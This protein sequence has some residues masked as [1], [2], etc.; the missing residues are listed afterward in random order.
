MQLLQ[1][2][3]KDRAIGFPEDIIADMNYVI[4]CYP[5]DEAIKRSVVELAGSDPV[6]D[7]WLS[8]GATIRDDVC[9]IEQFFVSQPTERTL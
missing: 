3:F 6:G 5:Y 4:W 8:F 2:I 1:P 9:R 7:T